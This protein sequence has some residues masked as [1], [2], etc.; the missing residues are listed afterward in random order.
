MKAAA[1]VF[2]QKGYLGSSVEEIAE[3][4]GFSIGAMYSNFA[5]KQDL[6][7]A[8][9]STRAVGRMD[10]V[11]RVIDTAQDQSVDPLQALGALL[12]AIADK[13]IEAAVLSTEFWLQ[14]VR[15]PALMQ[16]EANASDQKLL[17]VRNILVEILDR[18]HVHESVSVEEFAVTTLAL[19]S[20]LIR[21]RRI[22]PRRVS[23]EMFGRALRWQIDGMPKTTGSE[24]HSR[25][26]VEERE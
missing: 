22:D 15:N 1:E 14:A 2:A 26:G 19:F 10:E 13:D 4:A 3:T 24:P 11:A 12:M 5:T 7:A 21:Q 18:H 8:L 9:M 25:I 6:L 23:D 16:I 17:A 20:G